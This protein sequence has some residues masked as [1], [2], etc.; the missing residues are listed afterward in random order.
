MEQVILLT[1]EQAELLQGRMFT[2]D[3]YFLIQQDIDDNYFITVFEM[4][5]C[6]NPELQW[7]KK[8][9]RIEYK[10]KP[11]PMPEDETPVQE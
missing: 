4:E 11:Y 9:P 3:S 1:Q 6:T 7:I 8:C 5:H 2:L 10:P